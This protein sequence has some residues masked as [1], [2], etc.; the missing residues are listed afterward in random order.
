MTRK[1]LSALSID[2]LVAAFIDVALAM[3]K[4]D[5]EWRTARYN[6]LFGD[7]L[8]I[9][10]E[11]KARPGDQRTALLALYAYPNM[12]VRYQAAQ[13]TSSVAQAAARQALERIRQSDWP[14]AGPAG[15]ALRAWDEGIWKPD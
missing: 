7:K 8:A 13:A 12:E 1:A 14:Q 9:Q 6:K 11:L 10:N 5:K 3:E 2:E 15:M 4:A